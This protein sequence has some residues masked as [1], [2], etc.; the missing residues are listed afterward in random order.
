MIWAITTVCGNEAN[1]LLDYWIGH[2]CQWAQRMLICVTD[3]TSLAAPPKLFNQVGKVIVAHVPTKYAVGPEQHDMHYRLLLRHGLNKERDWTIFA[4]LDEFYAFP[5]CMS[6]VIA[7]CDEEALPGV[8]GHF[9]DMVAKDGSLNYVQPPVDINHCAHDSLRAQFPVETR[10]T[11]MLVRGG[12][13]KVMLCRGCVQ[14]GA[15]HHDIY[16]DGRPAEEANPSSALL[17]GGTKDVARGDW[18]V[19]H[20]KWKAELKAR[21]EEQLRSGAATDRWV[22]EAKHLL[23][24]FSRHDNKVCFT[25]PVGLTDLSARDLDIPTH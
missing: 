25:D 23:D 10:I 19:H 18:K 17:W 1:G 6:K 7:A 8:F 3:D 12:T 2:Y 9:V 14:V 11:E 15:G 13:K 21:L 24:Y 4:D 5:A 22:R 16:I 20:Y